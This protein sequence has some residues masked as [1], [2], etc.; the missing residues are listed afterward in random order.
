MLLFIL[1]TPWPVLSR[2]GTPEAASQIK[3]EYEGAVQDWARK[4][5]VADPE[6]QLNVWKNRPKPSVY[7]SRMWMELKDSLRDDWTIEYCV[8]ILE[9]AP[10]FAVS[11]DPG[12]AQSC[13]QSIIQFLQ[14]V[15]LKSPKVGMLCLALTSQSDPAILKVIEAVE[16][17]NPHEEVQGQASLAIA[18]LLKGL[19]DDA[20]IMTRRIDHLRRA[21][22]KAHE[23]KVGDTTVSKLAMDEI[24][25]IQ[26]LT[27]GRTAPDVIGRDSAGEPFKLSM[28]KGRVTVLAFWHTSMRDAERGL[29]L[30]RKLYEQQ[31]KRGMNLIGVT[32]DSREVLRSLRANGTIPWRNFSDLNGRIHSEYRVRDL[33]LVYVLDGERKIRYIGGPGAFVD[34]T[35]EGMLAQ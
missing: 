30:L 3:K 2:A 31:G 6:A 1:A 24:F 13:A 28:L 26:N 34:L 27:K 20:A 10:V 14:R 12:E 17:E 23:V 8:W 33:P 35:V 19:G 21:I 22:I 11:T 25:V 16:K 29:G 32:S 18:M 9:R 15:H 5:G 7:G 4:L